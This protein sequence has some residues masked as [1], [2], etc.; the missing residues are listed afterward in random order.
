MSTRAPL[1][2]ALLAGLFVSVSVWAGPPAIYAPGVKA[3][4]PVD[5]NLLLKEGPLE[6]WSHGVEVRNLG[7]NDQFSA[8]LVWIKTSERLHV[9]TKHDATVVL[10]KGKGTFRYAQQEIKVKEGDVFS[11][12]RGT[13]HAF[14]NGSKTPAAAYVVFSPPFDG[15]DTIEVNDVVQ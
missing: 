6:S 14:T 10:L 9:H 1:F 7:G 5:V 15:K 2:L 4:V 13:V 8:H 11:V 12:T 3:L